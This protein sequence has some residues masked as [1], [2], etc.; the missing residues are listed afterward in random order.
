MTKPTRIQS[1]IA[2]SGWLPL[3]A[4]TEETGIPLE[5]LKKEINV[6]QL[7]A[8]AIAGKLVVDEAG[9][10]EFLIRFRRANKPL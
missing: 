1:H 2:S 6:G 10:E 4:A 7:P 3:A 9:L 5:L 8:A